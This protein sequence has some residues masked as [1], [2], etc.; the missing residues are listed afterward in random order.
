MRKD[1]PTRS[2]RLIIRTLT[3][4]ALAWL[5]LAAGGPWLYKQFDREP[6]ATNT[7]PDGRFRLAYYAVPFLPYRLSSYNGMGCSDC[8]G[9]V[10]L[11]DKAKKNVLQEKY[12]QMSHDVSGGISWDRSEVRIKLFAAWPLPE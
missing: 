2:V 1:F 9:Y 6:W 3:I 12:F 5:L 8:P 10:R 7:S 4:I 11:V